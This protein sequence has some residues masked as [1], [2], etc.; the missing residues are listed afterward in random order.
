MKYDRVTYG[1]AAAIKNCSIWT[2]RREIERLERELGRDDLVVRIN[3]RVVRI[4]SS[5]LD[6][7]AQR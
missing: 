7:I 5:T 4:P 6:L 1:E 2:I 3:S